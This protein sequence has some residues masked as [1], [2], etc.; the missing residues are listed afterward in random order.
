MEILAIKSW[1]LHSSV[2]C[3]RVK[4]RVEHFQVG[5]LI[6]GLMCKQDYLV[7]KYDLRKQQFYTK[8][9]YDLHLKLLVLHKNEKIANYYYA[10]TEEAIVEAVYGHYKIKLKADQ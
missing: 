5:D 6:T 8:W 3:A 10:W 2:S 4:L 7:L 9:F 1:G